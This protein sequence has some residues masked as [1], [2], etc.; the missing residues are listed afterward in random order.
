MEALAVWGHPDK[1]VPLLSAAAQ[2]D[3][4]PILRV[5]AA[6]VLARLGDG[7]GLPRLR[8]SLDD[9]SWVVRAMAARYLGLFGTAD[10]YDLLVSRIGRETGNDF[11]VAEYC[12]AALKLFGRKGA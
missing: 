6:A 7:A 11:V 4:E 10:D 5:Y 3:A 2:R 8:A 9:Q 1:S 12:I